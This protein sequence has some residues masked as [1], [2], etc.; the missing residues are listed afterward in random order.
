[1]WRVIR[2]LSAIV[3]VSLITFVAVRLIPVNATTVG[4]VYLFFILVIATAWGFVEAAAASVAATGLYN[5]FFLPPV[6]TLTVADPQ[7]WVALITFLATSLLASRLSI[8]RDPF[9]SLR[10]AEWRRS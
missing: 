8:R 7:N 10:C 4:F 9:R 1:M 5:F 3:G 6:R 2:T